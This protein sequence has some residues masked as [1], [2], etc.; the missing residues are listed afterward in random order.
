MLGDQQ[1]FTSPA[2]PI[3]VN[4]EYAVRVLRADGTAYP[5]VRAANGQV[6]V[7]ASPGQAFKVEFTWLAPQGFHRA[8]ERL[9]A[10]LDIDGKSSGFRPS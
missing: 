6:F 1:K 5:E 3:V 2:A 10:N 9:G 4:G 8:N 7:V